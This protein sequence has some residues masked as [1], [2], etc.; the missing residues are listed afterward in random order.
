MQV[1]TL[2]CLPFG[3]FVCLDLCVCPLP[4]VCVFSSSRSG[5]PA[6]GD[7]DHPWAGRVHGHLRCQPRHHRGRAEGGQCA[8]NPGPAQHGPDTPAAGTAGPGQTHPGTTHPAH[9]GNISYLIITLLLML[10][11]SGTTGFCSAHLVYRNS[12]LF[13]TSMF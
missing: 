4:C 8:Q 6:G 7:P 5:R 1:L 11:N 9:P 10:G 3:L 2:V 12:A 13:K